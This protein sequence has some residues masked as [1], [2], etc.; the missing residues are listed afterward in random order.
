M[1]SASSA[2]SISASLMAEEVV[3]VMAT[4]AVAEAVAVHGREILTRMFHSFASARAR[5]GLFGHKVNYR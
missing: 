3:A 2:L 5:A 1:L 4:E